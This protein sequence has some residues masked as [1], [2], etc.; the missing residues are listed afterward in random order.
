ME[1]LTLLGLRMAKSTVQ[2]WCCFNLGSKQRN[3]GSLTAGPWIT[4]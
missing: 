2:S 1:Q 4:E 3:G